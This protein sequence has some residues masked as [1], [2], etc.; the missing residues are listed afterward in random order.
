MKNLILVLF[1]FLSLVCWSYAAQTVTTVSVT[2]STAGTQIVA[3]VGG[4]TVVML[5]SSAAVPVWF[6]RIQGTCS[7]VLTSQIGIRVTPGNGYEFLPRD[8]GYTS[9]IC[10]VLESGSTAV[11]VSVNTW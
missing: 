8:D 3:N 4:G 9:Q 11:T 1:C 2:S 6:A 5:P 7:S 10:A